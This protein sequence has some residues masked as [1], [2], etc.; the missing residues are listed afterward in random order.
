MLTLL[1]VTD[2]LDQDNVDRIGRRLARVPLRR[3]INILA[4]LPPKQQ[5]RAVWWFADI[6]VRLHDRIREL[7]HERAEPAEPEL[8]RRALTR[9]DDLLAHFYGVQARPVARTTGPANLAVVPAAS[10]RPRLLEAL[11]PSVPVTQPDAEPEGFINVLPG[12]NEPFRAKLIKQ[13]RD[14]VD[15]QY[16]G[17]AVGRGE[18]EHDAAGAVYDLADVENAARLIDGL[19]GGVRQPAPGYAGA[20]CRR[21]RAGREPLRPVRPGP[22]RVQPHG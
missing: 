18:A 1:S 11:V 19:V 21:V 15:A 7:I 4:E 10:Q 6:R 9:L 2:P 12:E 16:Q 8:L 20:A 17:S 5:A 22:G 3:L 13:I 14:D